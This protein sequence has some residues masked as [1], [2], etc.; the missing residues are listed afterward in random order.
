MRHLPYTF[1]QSGYPDKITVKF[2]DGEELVYS[3]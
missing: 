3:R 1:D 2:E